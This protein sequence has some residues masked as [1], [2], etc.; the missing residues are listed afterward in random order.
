MKF[1]SSLVLLSSA[2]LASF[3]LAADFKLTSVDVGQDKPLARDFV[4]NGYGCTGGNQSPALAW[5]GAPAGT[6]SYALMLFDPDAMQG[7]GFWHWLM[8]DI[9]STATSLSRDA[10]RADGSKA[11]AGAIQIKNDFRTLGY[12][13]S[14]PPTSDEPHGY[15]YTL[16]ALKVDKLDVAANSPPAALLATI[17][18]NSLGKATLGYHFG[19]KPK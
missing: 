15:V 17:E 8:I 3:A 1:L 14:C 18:A 12:G 19:R 10:G 11:P 13:G 4:F 5:S 2:L 9:P 6:R 16:Y 7:K